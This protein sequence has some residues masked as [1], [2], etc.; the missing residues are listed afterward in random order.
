MRTIRNIAVEFNERKTFAHCY[1]KH[2]RLLNYIKKYITDEIL[3]TST[4]IC[5][6]LPANCYFEDRGLRSA[7]IEGRDETGHLMAKVTYSITSCKRD[8]SG[9]ET[10]EVTIPE[11]V[12][13]PKS[14]KNH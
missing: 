5:F 13:E 9:V 12:N 7:L 2:P 10:D 4:P 1:A 3:Q 8:G 11:F 6:S 14:K